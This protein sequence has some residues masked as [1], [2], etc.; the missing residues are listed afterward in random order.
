MEYP[1]EV[2]E[3][4]MVVVPAIACAGIFVTASVRIP[5]VSHFDIGYLLV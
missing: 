2:V 3:V 5:I 4:E 1:V